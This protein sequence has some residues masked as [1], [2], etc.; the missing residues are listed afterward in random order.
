MELLLTVGALETGDQEFEK[1]RVETGLSDGIQIE[2]V[3]GVNESDRV[4]DPNTANTRSAQRCC[5]S[6]IGRA[7]LRL[8]PTP[9][10]DGARCRSGFPISR[11]V[12]ARH[13]G[14]NL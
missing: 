9:G 2:I 3:S 1:C 12:T 10:I 8:L 7:R 5:S 6:G 11:Q 13:L 14:R 4:K